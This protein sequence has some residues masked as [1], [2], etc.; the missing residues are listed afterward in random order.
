MA[1][2]SRAEREARLQARLDKAVEMEKQLDSEIKSKSEQ[3]KA[4]DKEIQQI[5]VDL[6]ASKRQS[7]PW[8]VHFHDTAAGVRFDY[9]RYQKDHAD[10]CAA[11]MV[12]TAP[13]IYFRIV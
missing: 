4:L 7:G 5:M 9:S 10:L 3:K 1:G 11:Y 6:G 13:G 2:I 12:E 8:W